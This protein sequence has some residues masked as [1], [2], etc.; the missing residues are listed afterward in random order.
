[1]NHI[2]CRGTFTD[3]KYRHVL[4]HWQKEIE[5]LR[6]LDGPME[7]L[8][9]GKTVPLRKGQVCIINRGRMHRISSPIDSQESTFQQLTVDPDLFTADR[10]IFERYIAPLLHK[11]SVSHLVFSCESGAGKDIAYCMQ[12]VERLE[13]E[14][15][16]AYELA[17]IAWLHLLFQHLYCACPATPG[18]VTPRDGDAEI[19]RDCV[20]FIAAH[21]GQ[22]IGLDQIAASGCVSRN[23]CCSL[24]KKYA[25][26]SPVD[27]LNYF[28]LEQ[29]GK[30]LRTT[31]LS[32]ADIAQ[33]CGFAQQ[34]YFNRCFLRAYGMTPKEYRREAAGT[35]RTVEPV[36]CEKGLER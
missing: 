16:E 25:A 4:T 30:L 10:D 8:I 33:R 34:S 20:S 36:G 23:K 17:V 35:V 21:Y 14:R 18:R 5:L 26:H 22:K 32:M 15:G 3:I 1:M 9:E 12:Q 24:F 27:Y 31:S 2:S 28:R 11:A 29:S 6:V 19:F 7:C 13:E